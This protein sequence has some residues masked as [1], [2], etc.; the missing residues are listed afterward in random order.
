MSVPG[1]QRF[2]PRRNK[3]FKCLKRSKWRFRKHGRVYCRKQPFTLQAPFGVPTVFALWSGVSLTERLK[4]TENQHL[5]SECVNA[6]KSPQ[7]VMDVCLLPPTTSPCFSLF[8]QYFKFIIFGGQRERR[9]FVCLCG[10]MLGGG[11]NK[12]G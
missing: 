11:P 1:A 5:E 10:F 7:T 8:T 4:L 6:V 3:T 2:P 9:V 12:D